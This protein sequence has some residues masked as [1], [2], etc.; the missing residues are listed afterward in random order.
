VKIVL[1][2]LELDNYPLRKAALLV[3]ESGL[4]YGKE[5]IVELFLLKRRKYFQKLQ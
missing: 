5:E 4:A 2:A 3:L 1:K